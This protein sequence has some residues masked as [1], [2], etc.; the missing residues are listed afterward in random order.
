MSTLESDHR[1]LSTSAR[2]RLGQISLVMVAVIVALVVAEV[3][4]AAGPRQGLSAGIGRADELGQVTDQASA[5]G[6][7][8]SPAKMVRRLAPAVPYP[9]IQARPRVQRYEIFGILNI[10]GIVL[11]WRD[12]RR[13][14]AESRRAEEAM[15]RQHNKLQAMISSIE[16]GVVFADASDMIIEANACFGGLV[17]AD[18]RNIIGRQVHGLFDAELAEKIRRQ[19]VRFRTDFVTEPLSIQCPLN[20]SE[21]ICRCHAIYQGGQYDG[22]FL[23][24]VNVTELVE[25]R[26]E[27]ERASQQL[28][29]RAEELESARG[30]LLNVVDD[31]EAREKAL[32]AANEFQ[33]KLLATA[34]SAVFTVDCTNHITTVNEVFCQITGYRE[35]EAIGQEMDILQWACEDDQDDPLHTPVGRM[36]KKQYTI[37]AKNGRKLTILRSADLIHD[38]NGQMVGGIESFMDVTELVEAR[39]QAEKA[40]KAKGEFLAK[41]SHEIRTPMNGIIGM[42]DLALDTDLTDDQREY[43]TLVKDSANSLLEIINDIL[44]S[45]KIESGKLSLEYTAFSL[46]DMIGE[47]MQSLLFRA[48]AKGIDMQ[49]Q[50]PADVPDELMGDPIRLRQI[51]VNLCGNAIKFTEAGS[52]DLSVEVKEL[53]DQ[54]VCLHFMVAD[55]GIGIPADKQHSIFQAF[56]QAD[57]STTRRYGGT[58]LGLTISGQLVDMMDGTIWV[59]SEVGKGSTFHFTVR[60]GLHE[61]HETI[62]AD[63]LQAGM[64]GMA[65]LVAGGNATEQRM[66]DKTLRSWGLVP[67]CVS[68]AQDALDALSA[69][70]NAD[71]SYHLVLAHGDAPKVEAIDLAR[72]I[73]D[74]YPGGAVKVMLMGSAHGDHDPAEWTAMGVSAYLA[75]PVKHSDLW[76]AILTVMAGAPVFAQHDETGDSQP[77]SG[78]HG[79]L[80]ILLAEDNSVNQKLMRRL[81]AKQGHT[82][83]IAANGAEAVECL[84]HE[85]FD[86]VLMDIQMPKLSG[87]EATEAIRQREKASGGHMPIIALTAHAMKGDLEKCL[88]AGMDGYLA[89]PAQPED[90]QREIARVLDAAAVPADSP[91]PASSCEATPDKNGSPRYE[92]VPAQAVCDVTHI[93]SAFDPIRLMS[94]VDGDVG[95]LSEIVAEFLEDSPRLISDID[96]AVLTEDAVGLERAAHKLKGTV[97]NFAAKSAFDA[98]MNL[99]MAGGHNNMDR[100]RE[101]FADVKRTVSELAAALKA[102]TRE[103][104]SCGS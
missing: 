34:A 60:L 43:L 5:G 25:A 86:L 93:N 32:Q 87:I 58:G 65:V 79:S 96:T 64:D 23:S 56:E 15:Q 81:L 40:N 46:R 98:A 21:V 44:D 24:L 45:S 104:V 75:K 12:L 100:A 84:D 89:K 85:Q 91:V 11:I 70:E 37:K 10:I 16:D 41:M 73:A 62:Q 4:Y 61:T 47:T 95:L 67:V 57:G 49:W 88:K 39:K 1:W 33:Q 50:T 22:M 53:T 2:R 103:K 18:Q 69:A 72:Q 52:I 9:R 76:N 20:G 31:L 63:R 28:R 94:A 19:A 102:F 7:I 92:N 97:G 6:E 55:T 54:Q 48:S 90:I 36:V 66:I 38:E 82:I 42:T 29:E 13:R 3:L 83:T 99:E 8:P 68:T 71:G 101:A 80:H 14:M 59:A 30:A 78:R 27:A 26:Q 74:R 77:S 35:S 17:G 51:I